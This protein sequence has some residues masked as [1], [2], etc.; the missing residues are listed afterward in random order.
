MASSISLPRNYATDTASAPSK[1]AEH[2]V[3]STEILADAHDSKQNDWK[4]PK[5]SIQDLE[6][7]RLFQL[8]KRRDYE[9]QLNKN[10]LNYGQWMRYAKWEIEHNHDF[11]R[12]R[13]IMERALEVNVQHVPFW[14]R[15]VELELLHKNVN[16]ARNILDRAV[17]VLP[18]TDKFW[19]VYV[20]TEEALANY[21]GVR[22]VFERWLKWQPGSHAWEAYISFEERYGEYDNA[23]ALCVRYVAETGTNNAWRRL[24]LV[25]QAAPGEDEAHVA[26]IRGAFELALDAVLGKPDARQDPLV[27]ELLR[28]WVQWE[29]SVGE[30]ERARAIY[31]EILGGNYVLG[32]QKA[33]ILRDMADFQAS[34][35]LHTLESTLLV[36]RRLHYEKLVSLDVFDYD[37]W[38]EYV[39][40]VEAT[41]GKEIAVEELE[42]AVLTVPLDGFKL[43]R[44]RRYVFLWIKLALL[45]EYETKNIET[46]RETWRKALGEVPHASFTFAKL[47]IM[48]AEFE[49]RHGGGVDAGRKVLGRAIGQSGTMRPKKKLFTYYIAMETRLGEIDRARKLY[50]KWLEVAVV[51]DIKRRV[52][53]AGPLNAERVFL[54]Y[55]AFEKS[56]DERARCEALFQIA[57]SLALPLQ[58]AQIFTQHIEFLKEEFLYEKARAQ[59]R[60]R[61]ESEP[62]AGVWVQFALFESSILSPAQLEQLHSQEGGG[63]TEVRFQ[64]EPHHVQA[65]RATFEEAFVYY[66][67]LSDGENAGHIIDAWQA[68]E[69][70]HGDEEHR[71][72]AEKQRP[73]RVTKRRTANGI[74]EVYYEYEFGAAPNMAR[75]LANAHKWA[76][77]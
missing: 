76:Q 59:F 31:D 6:E 22:L 45:Q 26:Q 65:T 38:W 58:T 18:R 68:F 2:Q 23:R 20:Q 40:M 52:G 71:A 56:H 55:V 46:A 69:R 24:V 4:R 17:S 21:K 64:I 62:S 25:H 48:Y 50:E 29:A 74:E 8:M 32:T 43:T 15:Y 63:D 41:Q 33:E 73:T 47:W 19:Y 14:I 27:P 61:L 7:L 28:L 53:T 1:A 5:Q 34:S 3:T 54:E 67:K 30:S 37:S 77:R 66:K 42:Q 10:R 49:M 60:R 36:K 44:W 57:D 51:S 9:Q 72:K 75:I 35:G 39:K 13:S 16:H 12:A 70:A 11:R